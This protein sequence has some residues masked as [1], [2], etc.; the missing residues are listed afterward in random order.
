MEDL[1][2]LLKPGDMV[3]LKNVVDMVESAGS[4]RTLGALDNQGVIDEY[5]EYS[6]MVGT[7]RSVCETNFT[8]NEVGAVAFFGGDIAMWP[9]EFEMSEVNVNDMLEFLGVCEV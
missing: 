9:R 1:R 4:S 5:M 6:E 8:L 3:K 7:V 2:N